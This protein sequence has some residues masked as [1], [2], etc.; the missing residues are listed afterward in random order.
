MTTVKYADL[1][2]VYDRVYEGRHVPNGLASRGPMW[3][4]FIRED[5]EYAERYCK[6]PLLA[7]L[8]AEGISYRQTLLSEAALDEQTVTP[9]YLLEMLYS[10]RV[11]LSQRSGES[12]ALNPF[13]Q[14]SKEAIEAIR[15]GRLKLVITRLKRPERNG[16]QWDMFARVLG[17]LHEF[18]IPPEQVLFFGCG[19]DFTEHYRATLE[20][21]PDLPR[22]KGVVKFPYFERGWHSYFRHYLAHDQI[23]TPVESREDVARV[24]PKK[25]LNFNRE[26]RAHRRVVAGW[27]YKK[28]F[29]DQ[30]LT[31]FPVPS[32]EF[33]PTKFD[34][35]SE[36]V[37][38]IFRDQR[39]VE[40]AEGDF[41]G[42]AKNTPYLVDAPDLLKLHISWCTKAPFRD[43]YFSI[44]TERLYFSEN[45]QAL[46]TSKAFKAMSNMHPFVMVGAH[47]SLQFL[48]EMGYRT[49]SPMID[50]RYDL[51]PNSD[52][53]MWM[54][55]DEIERLIRL[56]DEEWLHLLA[57]LMPVLEYNY[58]HLSERQ[59]VPLQRYL[60]GL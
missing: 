1:H 10:F 58:Q 5:A 52:K 48:R 35:Y 9:I 38:D 31:S 22:L 57:S 15:T 21:R 44:L 42:F 8:D 39:L 33:D 37:R 11:W 56:S 59:I 41:T 3:Q 26:P 19:E 29:I 7:L 55:L 14:I 40:F 25:Y 50:E 23:Y 32:G 45:G 54:I 12:F 6:T 30:G 49:F 34:E 17:R 60:P 2:F 47:R 24:R 13:A 27:L 46:L 16:Y 28:G 4:R 43:T 20:R 51:E 36:G 53:R 18:S